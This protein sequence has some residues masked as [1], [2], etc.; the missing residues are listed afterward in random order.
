MNYYEQFVQKLA[1]TCES[2]VAIDLENAAELASE[3]QE[4][5]ATANSRLLD[6]DRLLTKGLRSEAVEHSKAQPDLLDLYRVLD[7]HLRPRWNE[8]CERNKLPIAPFL[9]E[10]TARQLNTAYSMEAQLEPFLKNHRLLALRRGPISERIAVLRQL[11]LQDPSNMGWIA[12]VEELELE[13]LGEIKGHL[14]D[15]YFCGDF[16]QVSAVWQELNDAG[17]RVPLPLEILQTANIRQEALRGSAASKTVLDKT[18]E[19]SRAM[20]NGDYRLAFA[21]VQKCDEIIRTITDAANLQETLAEYLTLRQQVINHLDEQKQT[22]EFNAAVTLFEKFISVKEP[23][24]DDWI[25]L[26]HNLNLRFKTLESFGREIPSRV[27]H[28]YDKMVRECDRLQ[29][30]MLNSK[31]LAVI[32]GIIGVVVI[33]GLVVV[34]LTF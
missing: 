28:D 7:F 5:C 20:S 11:L 22:K 14:N 2:P 29:Q 1:N 32:V 6:V 4:L 15:S 13:R 25:E 8:L 12:D 9:H 19:L 17:W 23:S 10:Q 31:R 33:A 30:N 16:S 27:R 34:G 26:K 21:I 24:D 3:Y 18:P